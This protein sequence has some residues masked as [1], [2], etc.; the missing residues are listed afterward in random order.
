MQLRGN[1]KMTEQTD[2]DLD[3]EAL[4]AESDDLGAAIPPVDS[5][6]GDDDVEAEEE[7]E[8]ESDTGEGEGEGEGEAEDE[9]DTEEATER[10]DGTPPAAEQDPAVDFKALY[11]RSQREV[12][13][14]TGRLR[15]TEARLLKEKEELERKL[16]K[17]PVAPTED[18]T[19]L[20]E[21]SEKYTPEVIRAID[22]I[23]TKKARS[24]IDETLASRVAPL[25]SVTQDILGDAH[26][27]A[28]ESIHPDLEAID[29]SPIFE[30]WL[31]SRPEYLKPLYKQ[32]R[33]N[34]TPAQ[35]IG[36]LNEYKE[37]IGATQKTKTVTTNKT[38]VIAATAVG[39]R[40]G[41]AAT[42]K[43]PDANDLE[44]IWAETDD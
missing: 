44:A 41:T 19:F 26:F 10:S 6:A 18:D 43:Q 21:F 25:E 1:T 17:T 3:L 35:V 34:G 39:R 28:I 14:M 7:S 42:A 4:W 37:T 2:E 27:K 13:T 9:S 11:E 12:Q 31:E 16:P 33:E 30:S 8:S 40:R 20:T 15:A 23:T 24:M 36:M 29:S 32:I 5:M 38:N 22:L